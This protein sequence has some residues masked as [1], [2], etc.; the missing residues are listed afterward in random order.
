M[1]QLYAIGDSKGVDS[2]WLK[3]RGKAGDTVNQGMEDFDRCK[4][5]WERMD[6]TWLFIAENVEDTLKWDN[7]LISEITLKWSS[8][9]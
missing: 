2:I 1:K 3:V 9:I 7:V 4:S 5:K 8:T 6:R